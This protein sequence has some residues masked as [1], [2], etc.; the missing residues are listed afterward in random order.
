MSKLINNKYIKYNLMIFLMIYISFCTTNLYFEDYFSR[1][2]VITLL[3][4]NF[5]WGYLNIFIDSKKTK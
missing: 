3:I 2:R 5:V 1:P 4:F